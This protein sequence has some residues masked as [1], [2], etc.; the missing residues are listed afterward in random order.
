[1]PAAGRVLCKPGVLFTVISPAGF[2]LL[3]SLERAAR[4]CAVDLT[5]TSACDGEHSGPDDPHHRGDAFDVRSHDLADVRKREI[6]IAVLRFCSDGGFTEPPPLAAP[7]QGYFA[8]AFFGF[9]ED[10]GGPNAHLHFQL[11]KG[12]TYPPASAVG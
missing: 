6:L 10:A 2:R 1:M 3:S 12:R 11:R 8:G 7:S 9:L 5:I 4:V